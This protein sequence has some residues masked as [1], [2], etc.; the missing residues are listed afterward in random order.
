MKTY[1]ENLKAC[2]ERAGLSQEAMAAKMGL[3]DQGNL[4]QYENDYKFPKVDLI[5]RHARACGATTGELLDGVVDPYDAL[6]TGAPTDETVSAHTAAQDNRATRDEAQLLLRHAREQSRMAKAHPADRLARAA[7]D[8]LEVGK[9]LRAWRPPTVA[10]GSGPGL[11]TRDRK[12][13]P[14]S[15]SKPASKTS[16]K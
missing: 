16:E 1:G 7:S 2:R 8:L 4:P 12:G 15:R 3:A 13:R 9:Q 6:R 10:R 14:K 5:K 11:S